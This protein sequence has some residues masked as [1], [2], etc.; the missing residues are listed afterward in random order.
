MSGELV[1]IIIL[2]A[3]FFALGFMVKVVS[4]N[5]A[6]KALIN[7]QASPDTI[8]KLFLQH[9]APD[10]QNALK[11]GLVIVGIG[12]SFVLLQVLSLDDDEPLSYGLV[13]LCGGGGLLAYYGIGTVTSKD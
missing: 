13:F 6:R 5:S 7:S 12:I 4:D 2:P 9:R 3:F 10:L 11:W 1:P 8:D